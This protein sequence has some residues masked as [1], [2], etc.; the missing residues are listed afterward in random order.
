MIALPVQRI[1]R[2]LSHRPEHPPNDEVRLAALA[3]ELD[4]DEAFVDALF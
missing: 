1:R 4:L 2:A 3:L